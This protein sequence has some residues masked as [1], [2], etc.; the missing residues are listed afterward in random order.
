MG[1]SMRA[2]FCARSLPRFQAWPRE[3]SSISSKSLI[4]CLPVIAD[5]H[6]R[7]PCCRRRVRHGHLW[8][9]RLVAAAPDICPSGQVFRIRW[10]RNYCG[11]RSPPSQRIRWSRGRLQ[12]F[13]HAVVFC[14]RH[15]SSIAC[16]GK[17]RRMRRALRVAHSTYAAGGPVPRDRLGRGTAAAL[18][19]HPRS[20]RFAQRVVRGLIARLSI[21]PE[22]WVR[23]THLGV[24]RAP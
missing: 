2:P 4:I 9:Y 3:S 1:S 17:P 6:R 12:P 10:S 22:C 24:F 23:R 14:A 20:V 11:F 19:A 8:L 13:R 16:G 7:N 21:H 15:C 5:W 18:G